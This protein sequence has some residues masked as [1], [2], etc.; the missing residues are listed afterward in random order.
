MAPD[1]VFVGPGRLPDPRAAPGAK[2]YRTQRR[3]RGL[4]RGSRSAGRIT[5]SSDA[6]FYNVGAQFWLQ[7]DRFGGEDGMQNLLRPWGSATSTGVALTGES[8]G[9]VPTTAWKLDFCDRARLRPRLAHRRQR[10]HG[11]R[12]GRRAGDPAA[13]GQRLRHLRQRRHPLRAADRPAGRRR[14]QTGQVTQE[15][16][17]EVAA[18]GATCRP[19]C[20][21]RCS[22]GLVGVP[23]SGTATRAFAGF[24]LDDFPI[25]GKTGTAQVDNKADTAVFTAF[26]PVAGAPLPG[27]G[28]PRGV[29]L[30]RHRRRPGGPGAVR[31][32]AGVRPLQPAGPDGLPQGG[33]RRA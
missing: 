18:A 23:R 9:R 15:F 14:Y 21:S 3:R 13:A 28:V 16:A 19:R 2:C 27:V 24:P 20:A 26:G 33:G 5:V 25:A 4:R 1:T 17:P 22:T 30:R 12:P 11:H 6:Y 7:R 31:V 29:G 8:A 32:L 10:Q